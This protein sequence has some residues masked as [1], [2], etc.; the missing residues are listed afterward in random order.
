MSKTKNQEWKKKKV[1]EWKKSEKSIRGWCLE[2][3]ISP[4]T[5]RYWRD[6]FFPK[7]TKTKLKK[8]FFTE[9]KEETVSKIEIEIKGITIKIFENFDESLLK[10]CL[11]T[12]RSL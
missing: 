9:V 2:K 1:L 5:L 8:D 10:K 11:S 4:S 6:I 7:E 12:I 3:S